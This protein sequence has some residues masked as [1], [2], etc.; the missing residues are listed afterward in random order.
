MIPEKTAP[1]RKEQRQVGSQLEVEEQGERQVL[2]QEEEVGGQEV[3]VM[4]QEGEVLP[5]EMTGEGWDGYR[6]G[7]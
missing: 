4:Q 3:V 2:Q 7:C 6:R 1:K 5:R